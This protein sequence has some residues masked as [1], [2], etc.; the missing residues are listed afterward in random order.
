MGLQ[1]EREEKSFECWESGDFECLNVG[2]MRKIGRKLVEDMKIQP[3]QSRGC[4]M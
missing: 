1:E 4:S 2:T 3:V